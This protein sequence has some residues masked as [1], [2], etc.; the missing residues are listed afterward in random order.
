MSERVLGVSGDSPGYGTLLFAP[1]PLGLN[2]AKGTVPTPKGDVHV[3]WTYEHNRFVYDATLPPATEG[4][5]D[6]AGIDGA[7]A[8]QLSVDGS[9]SVLY[10]G[11]IKLGA[12]T[13]HVVLSS[14]VAR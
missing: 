8:M 7:A 13:H 2:F 12:G 4:T 11:P 6:L 1:I 14:S 3:S 9:Q 5:I 10:R